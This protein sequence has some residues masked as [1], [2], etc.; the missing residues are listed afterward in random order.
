M[1]RARELGRIAIDTETTSLDPMQA[2]LCGF[3]LALNP[4][5]A[6]YVP[7]AHRRGG[8]AGK[9]SL[10]PGTLAPDQIA[11]GAAL[12]A[13]KPLLED[14]GVLKVGQNLKFDLQIF[15]L[16]GIELAPFDDTMLMSYVL[17]AGR[18]DHGLDPLSKL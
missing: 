2:E 5:E 13:I 8:E 14:A 6:C 16:R 7:L 1:A 11:E 15:A 17:D 9:D 18:T 10:F 4:N 12:A 3:S